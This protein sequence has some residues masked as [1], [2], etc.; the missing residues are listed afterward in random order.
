[1]T[2]LQKFLF[3]YIKQ[4]ETVLLFIRATRDR[5][6]ELHLQSLESLIKYFFAHD[7]MNY[8]PLLPLY[9]ATM[10]KRQKHQT[11]NFQENELMTSLNEISTNYYLSQY[12]RNFK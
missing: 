2:P 9:L 10:Q 11:T 8:A 6:I 1:M 5:D 7:H 4:F 12:L 3:N